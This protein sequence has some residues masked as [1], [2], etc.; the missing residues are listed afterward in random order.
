MG[1][2][3]YTP[4]AWQKTL[5]LWASIAFAVFVNTVVSSALPKIEGL[6]LILHVLGFFAI[7]IPLVYL[8]PHGSAR[9]VFTVF[10]NEGGWPTQGLAFMLGMIASVFNFLGMV[11]AYPYCNSCLEIYYNLCTNSYLG[12]DGAVHVSTT[13]LT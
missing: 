8:S 7:L 4:L 6:V 9:E 2:A 13:Y 1:N 12:A 5:L 10:S 11:P 3:N